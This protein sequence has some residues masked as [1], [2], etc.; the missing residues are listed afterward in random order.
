MIECRPMRIFLRAAVL[1]IVASIAASPQKNRSQSPD[2]DWPMFNRDSAGTRYSPLSQINT[3]NV[4]NLKV[5]WTYK[6]RPHDGK[7]LTGQSPSEVFQEVTPIVV[8]GVMYLPSANRVVALQPFARAKSNPPRTC[9][10]FCQPT[11]SV[12]PYLT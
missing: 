2:A 1:L 7:P 5:A 11:K 6:L 8:N 12:R 9:F 10:M 3:T 4:T